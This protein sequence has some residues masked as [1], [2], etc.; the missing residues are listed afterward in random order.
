MTNQS[1]YKAFSIRA[2]NATCADIA[3]ATNWRTLASQK[4]IAGDGVYE[5]GSTVSKT[6]VMQIHFEC[7]HIYQPGIHQR[8]SPMPDAAYNAADTHERAGR[9]LRS[10]QNEKRGSTN[11]T[12]H[13]W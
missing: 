6:N 10:G 13:S 5:D 4:T 12:I 7:G 8:L 3:R 11:K 9:I 1:R 2:L